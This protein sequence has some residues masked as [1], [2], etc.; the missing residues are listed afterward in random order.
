MSPFD[1]VFIDRDG[2]IGGTG[3]FIH[4]RDF[5]LYSFSREAFQLLKSHNIKMYAC[6]NQWRISQGQATMDDFYNEFQSYGFDDAFIC[7]HGPEDGCDCRKPK[8]GLLFEAAKKH[9]LD[10]KRTVF[11]GDVGE[12]DMLAADAVGAKKILVLT[13][14]G[15]ASCHEYRYTWA[16]VE[17]DYIAEN[18]LEAVKWII[19]SNGNKR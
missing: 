13:G 4:P 18:L 3:H 14:W 15:K 11:I 1:A 17:P 9:H 8:P 19:K 12:T 7:P 6:T 2:T 10:L 16:G 5:Q